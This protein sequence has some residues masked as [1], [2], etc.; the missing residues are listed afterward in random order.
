MTIRKQISFITAALL[1][2]CFSVASFSQTVAELEKQRKQKEKEI[3]LTKKL[4]NETGIKEKKSLDYLNVL[5]V[6]IETR[7]SLINTVR[8]E[9]RYI[10]E[11]ITDTKDIVESMEKDLQTLKAEY[12]SMVRFAYKTKNNYTKLGFIFSAESFNQSYKRLK[13]LQNYSEFR[14]KQ[15]ELILETKATIEE[16]LTELEKKKQK[17]LKLLNIRNS[18][19][20]NL[21]KDKSGQ[22]QLLGNLKKEKSKLKKDLAKKE[23]IKK[24]LNKKIEQIILDEFKRN[25]KKSNSGTFELTPEAAQLSNDFVNNKGKLPWPIEKGVISENF[26][27]HKHPTLDIDVVVNGIKFICPKGSEARAIFN[28]TVTRVFPIPGAGNS[29]L[30]NHGMY[31]TVYS[32]LDVVY[33]KMGEQITTKFKL[34][35]IRYDQSSGKTEM[36]L[37]IWKLKGAQ[38]PDK[39]NPAYW[40]YKK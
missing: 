29:V 36:E 1:V 27:R 37:Q 34:G 7:E 32:N 2:L 23:K 6:Q 21:I 20:E 15:M 5:N 39:Q 13:L 11:E 38:Q 10:N 25:S 3:E 33:V 30:V 19:K 40:I 24:D 22:A 16:K 28:G 35:K 17:Q 8:Q 4:I 26:G 14:K 9:L 12:A 31:Y 18:E